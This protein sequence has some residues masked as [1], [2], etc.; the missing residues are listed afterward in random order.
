[1]KTNTPKLR[2]KEFT[3]EWQEKKLGEI[4]SIFDGT[5]QTPDYV[6]TGIP[7][8]SVEHIT[9]G[10]FKDTKFVSEEVYEQECRR[11]KIERDDILMTRIG[12][13]GTSKYISWNPVASYYVSLALIKKTSP[14]NMKFLDQY[15]KTNTFQHRLWQRTIHVAFPKKI[16]LGEIGDCEISIP[17]ADEQEKI[18]DFLTVVDEK[19]NKLEE[20]KKRFEKYK[21]G[22][23]QAI[24]SQKIR[25]K[26]Q[27]GS[28][29]PDW[30]EKKLGEIVRMSTAPYVDFDRN[31]QQ[32]YYLIDMGSVLASGKLSANKRTISSNNIL[33]RGE[34]V[35]PNR[36]IGH[37][38][39][40]GKVAEIDQDNKYVLGNNM[41]CLCAKENVFS[42]YLFYAINSQDI[43]REMRKKSNGT[44][45]LQLIR[46][47]VDSQKIPLPNIE[48]QEKIAKFLT[49]L[50]NKVDLIN[51]ELEQAKLFKKSLLQQMF[52]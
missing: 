22:L 8:Y 42:R 2:F 11:V 21:K 16:N 35:M 36:D 47:D 27:D 39:I 19:I 23:M 26:R 44:S 3:D 38:D 37:G 10:N 7:F 49:S 34:L 9:S 17:D 46:K 48:E 33:K 18:A 45:Q 1:M 40:I 6:K 30:E 29:F 52:V 20:K 15:I 13:I 28:D 31:I 43:N 25:F 41:F 12:D 50:D 14:L 4:T 32:G 5:H 51:K 24:F